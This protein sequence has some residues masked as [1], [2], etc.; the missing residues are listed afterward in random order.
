MS[1]V[2]GSGLEY[3]TATEQE[4]PRGATP[5]PRS[6]GEAKRRYPVSE[7]RDGGREE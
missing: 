2:R 7:V 5:C 1:E 6:G 4:W 3:Q